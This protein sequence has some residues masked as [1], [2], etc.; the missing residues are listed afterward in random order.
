MAQDPEG[1]YEVLGLKAGASIKEVK[2]AF[3]KQ[4]L[5]YHPD[6]K[7]FKTAMKN[8]KTEAEKQKLKSEWEEKSKKLNQAKTILFDEQKKEAYDSGMSNFGGHNFGG[9]GDFFD[10][11]SQMTG[12]SRRNQVKKVKDT[13]YEV[14]LTFKESYL[15]KVSKFNVKVQREC[16]ACNGQGGDQVQTCNK[17]GGKGKIEHHRR[18]GPLISVSESPCT[19]CNETGRIVKGKICSICNGHQYVQTQ[20]KIELKI[21][22]GV[23][24]GRRFVFTG[25]G[26]QKKGYVSGD[27]II[28]TKIQKDPKF[29]RSGFN[30]IAKADIPLYTAL[31][32]GN[33][34]FDHVDGRKMEI[35]IRPFNNFKKCLVVRNEGFK[36]PNTTRCG[37]LFIDPNIIIDRIVDKDLLAKALRYTPTRNITSKCTEAQS[38]FSNLPEEEQSDEQHTRS[39]AAEDFFGGAASDFFSRVS[40][41]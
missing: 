32:G 36:K 4:Q 16:V 23:K 29:K 26:N 13:E 24:N 15:G 31:T 6:G 10:I 39:S 34:Y 11:F 14:T 41:F 33:I 40:F 12:G 19:T 7:L 25:K 35:Y 38:E 37:D 8:C 2:D 1:L 22:P 30:I 9:A 27:I 3:T 5:K 20:E 18:M 17:C 21:E 28:I